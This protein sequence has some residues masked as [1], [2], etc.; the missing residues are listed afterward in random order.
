MARVARVARER[1]HALT[2]ADTSNRQEKARLAEAAHRAPVRAS[3]LAVT[4]DK[5]KSHCQ[6]VNKVQ[7]NRLVRVCTL[8]C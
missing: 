6:D 2:G 3:A 1:P 4:D 8:N 7:P 5:G